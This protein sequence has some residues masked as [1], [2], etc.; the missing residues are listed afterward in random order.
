MTTTA[1]HILHAA[2]PVFAGAPEVL[3]ELFKRALGNRL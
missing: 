2:K 3:Q 1:D